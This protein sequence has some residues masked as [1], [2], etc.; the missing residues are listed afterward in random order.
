MPV[1]LAIVPYVCGWL[2]DF[3]TTWGC[4]QATELFQA[5]AAARQDLK[6]AAKAAG[7]QDSEV[8]LFVAPV[9]QYN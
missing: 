5:V 2:W 1:D 4:V 3:V 7:C 8:I 9:A 6:D